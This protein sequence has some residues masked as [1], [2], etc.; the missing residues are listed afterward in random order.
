[1]MTHGATL[2]T[3]CS[4]KGNW[5]TR[6]SGQPILGD[7]R[8]GAIFSM[9][10][11]KGVAALGVMERSAFRSVAARRATALQTALAPARLTAG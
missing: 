7:I 5:R 11:V 6:V 2:A 4:P 10:G 8:R 1:M 9:P 3:D